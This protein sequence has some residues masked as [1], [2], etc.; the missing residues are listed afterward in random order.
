[1]FKK[2]DE[3]TRMAKVIADDEARIV[4]LSHDVETARADYLQSR[5]A[6]IEGKPNAVENVERAQNRLNALDD[7]LRAASAKLAQRVEALADLEAK[8]ARQAKIETAR[9]IA[10][11]AAEI[12]KQRE[13]AEVRMRQTLSAECEKIA[14]ERA[15]RRR[16]LMRGVFF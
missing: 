12:E 10:R 14:Q 6:L 7:A 13:E 1:M 9:G 16:E 2:P 8:A 11:E 3:L 4:T 5:D 15:R